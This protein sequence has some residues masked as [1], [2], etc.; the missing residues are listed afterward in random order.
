MLV[1]WA[2]FTLVH[3]QDFGGMGG[4]GGGTCK[5]F[6][7][8]KGR[9]AV[10]SN[11][12]RFTSPGCA[13]MG[14]SMQMFSPGGGDDNNKEILPCCDQRHAC[15]SICGASKKRCEANFKKCVDD[16]CATGTEEQQKE[17]KSSTAIVTLMA[18]MSGC[19]DFDAIQAQNCKCVETDKVDK[20]RATVLTAFYKKWSDDS[21]DVVKDKV[22][23]LVAK[24]STAAKFANTLDKLAAKFP[25]SIKR[26]KDKQNEYMENL[27]KEANKDKGAK[28]ESETEADT[29]KD[30]GDTEDAQDEDVI[31]L[32]DEAPKTEL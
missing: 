6:K 26:V 22:T 24:H 4:M 14:G 29:L 10:P 13:G 17:C 15:L 8:S 18:Q 23:K 1:L 25:K 9:E 7:C 32:D 16:T 20:R 2:V 11:P 19:K 3:G 28:T 31:D 27:M 12:I 30:A 21:K 5:S